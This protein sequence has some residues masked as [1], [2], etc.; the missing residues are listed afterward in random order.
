MIANDA[1]AATLQLNQRPARLYDTK[2]WTPLVGTS[3][4]WSRG[5]SDFKFLGEP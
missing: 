2:M 1:L 4:S 5:I 3:R